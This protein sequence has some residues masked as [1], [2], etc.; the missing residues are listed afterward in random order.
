MH[1][2]EGGPELGTLRRLR[3]ELPRW[4][5][6]PKRGCVPVLSQLKVMGALYK[7]FVSSE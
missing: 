7:A 5:E 3:Q 4:W 1:D 2:G 6:L